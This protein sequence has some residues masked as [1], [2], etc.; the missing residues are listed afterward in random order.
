MAKTLLEGVNAVLKK[1]RVLD[2]QGELASLTDSSRQ[3]F[4]DTAIQSLNE[5]VDELYTGPGVSRPKQ[6]KER[7]LTLVANVTEYALPSAM[8]RL[9]TEFNLIDESNNHTIYLLEE[10][11]YWNII[12]GDSEQDDTGL[13]S[14]AAIS[15]VN[16][17]L[18]MDRKPTSAE[19][20]RAYKYRYDAD[21]ELE[22]ASDTFPF[23]NVVF[24]AMVPA[25]TEKWKA[26][27]ERDFSQGEY[28]SSVARAKRMLRQVPERN[29]YRPRRG[30]GNISDPMNDSTVS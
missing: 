7:T 6:M 16:G 9:R 26:H 20:G 14:T 15:P 24:R 29:T 2:A 12:V 19:D 10:G 30:G 23:S 5:I 18:R 21:T 28:N 1:A 17:R 8:D 4:I 22:S 3:M 11:G 13:P 25:A 27:N